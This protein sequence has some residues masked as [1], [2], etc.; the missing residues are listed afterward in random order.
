[1]CVKRRG[2]RGSRAEERDRGGGGGDGGGGDGGDG[3]DDDDEQVY[4]RAQ[5]H[6][7]KQGKA[8][9]SKTKAEEQRR[10]AGMPESNKGTRCCIDFFTFGS[11]ARVFGFRSKC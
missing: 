7:I 9:Q 3:G 4:G 5:L 2:E 8:K 11:S 6:S 10:E 1:M